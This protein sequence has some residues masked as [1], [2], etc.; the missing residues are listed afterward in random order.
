MFISGGSTH[1]HTMLQEIY[2]ALQQDK[3]VEFGLF[4]FV[5]HLE[6]SVLFPLRF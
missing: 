1:T 5:L 4:V 2:Q 6:S 3:H